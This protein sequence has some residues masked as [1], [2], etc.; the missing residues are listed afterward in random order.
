[1]DRDSRQLLLGMV[2]YLAAIAGI[3]A[4][5]GTAFATQ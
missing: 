1:M 4:T 5:L 2:A 3:I